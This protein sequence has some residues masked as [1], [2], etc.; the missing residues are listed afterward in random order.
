MLLYSSLTRIC[1]DEVL[2]TCLTVISGVFSPVNSASLT[3]HPN[4]PVGAFVLQLKVVVDPSVALTDVGVLTN[5]A[6][7]K[8][9]LKS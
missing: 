8:T 7:K 3:N 5:S 9:L 4:V 6:K 2:P 1:K